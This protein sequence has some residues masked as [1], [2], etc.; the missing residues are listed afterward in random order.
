[1]DNRSNREHYDLIHRKRLE[2]VNG[3]DAMFITRLSAALL[4]LTVVISGCSSA[5]APPTITP[6][7]I[8]TATLPPDATTYTIDRQQSSIKYLATGPFNAQYPGTFKVIGQSI[9]LI[10]VRDTY[11][12][13]IDLSFDLKSATATDSFM[14]NTLLNSLE[15]EK[16]PVAVLSLDSKD[17][18]RLPSDSTGSVTFTATGIYS[19]HGQQRTIEL[20]VTL[21]REG[22]ALQ[23]SGTMTFK[24]SDYKISIAGFVVSDEITFTTNLTASVRRIRQCAR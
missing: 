5:V 2:I 9:N 7:P 12:G 4:S 10:P 24:L 16:Y 3:K 19:L 1:V 23:L 21:S 6:A 18:I 15:V 17:T 13:N 8:S 20:P 14:R 22:D 11:H